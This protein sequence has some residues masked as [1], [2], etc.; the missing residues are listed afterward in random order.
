[1]SLTGII[2]DL[3]LIRTMAIP[4]V[5]RIKT[6]ILQL[7]PDKRIPLHRSELVNK[8]YPFLALRDP[9]KEAAF[10]AAILK[11]LFELDYVVVTAVI[12]KQ[13]HL[14]MYG[15]WARDP[16]HYC[17]QILFERYCLIL[18]RRRA[19]GDLMSEAR[20]KREDERLASAYG[21]LY[22][23]PTPIHR[24]VVNRCL[25]SKRLKIEKKSENVTGLQIA[26][27]IAH[28]SAM[29]ART[30]FNGEPK[31]SGF[32]WEIVQTL[33]RGK[34]YHRHWGRIKGAGLKWLP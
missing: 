26:D 21:Q 8:K 23:Y 31:P 10:N 4:E 32:G 27:L 12:D 15:Q 6:E 1:L 17:L 18:N 34:K 25:T 7:D 22:E 20:G 2:V 13:R 28:P 14:E 33:R 11:L 5:Q 24:D 29:L 16:Y 19:K 9:K 3:E 30:W